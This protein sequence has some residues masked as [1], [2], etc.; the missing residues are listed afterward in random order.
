MYKGP[1][2]RAVD[3]TYE[4]PDLQA[5]SVF[6]DMYPLLVLSKES[7]GEVEREIRVRIGEQGVSEEWREERVEL[8]RYGCPRFFSPIGEKISCGFFA[9]VP[10]E[11]RV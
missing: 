4:F 7:M 8:R 3:T 6:Q 10:P 11:Y 1:R 5:T 2:A 9:Q